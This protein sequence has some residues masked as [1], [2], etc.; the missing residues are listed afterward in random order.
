MELREIRET[1]YTEAFALAWEVFLA[2]E[3][4]EYDEQGVKEFYRSIHD[5]QYVEQLQCYGAF[6]G[7]QLVGMIA[8]RN[9]GNHVAAFLV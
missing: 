1:E 2:F 8:T 5:R 6:F 3:A 9:D 4:P 7:G